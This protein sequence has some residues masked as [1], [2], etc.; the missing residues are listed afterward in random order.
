VDA[1]NDFADSSFDT[2]LITQICNVLALFSNDDTG[3]FGG[4][5]R[6]KSQGRL[7][8]FLFCLGHGIFA[9]EINS[10]HLVRQSVAI[11]LRGTNDLLGRHDC[12][13]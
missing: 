13:N 4:D 1:L 6:T 11:D 12:V 8:V 5:D 7:R 9:I 3:F 10:V 2:S